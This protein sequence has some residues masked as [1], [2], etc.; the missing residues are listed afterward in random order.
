Q[1]LT[2]RIYDIARETELDPARGLS[3]RLGN[4]VFFI[5]RVV[6]TNSRQVCYCLF[7]FDQFLRDFPEHFPVL[8]H[9]KQTGLD[10]FVDI[11]L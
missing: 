3:A 7:V 4:P 6:F 11:F 9:I 1:I 2:A 8:I 5:K 10:E